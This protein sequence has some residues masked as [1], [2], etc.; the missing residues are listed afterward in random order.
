M[1]A[2]PTTDRVIYWHRELPPLAAEAMGEHTIE[3]VSPRVPATIFHTEESWGQCRDA[4]V[5]ATG[6]R[7]EQEVK[8]LGGRCAHVVHELID[9]RHDDA[10]S[11][12]WLHGCFTY[13]LYR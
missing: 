5:A 1:T 4:L 10:T 12:A 13:V 8:R 3:A 2:E 6:A 7:L 9:T 11:E